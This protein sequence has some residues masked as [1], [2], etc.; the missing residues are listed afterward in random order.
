MSNQHTENHNAELTFYGALQKNGVYE[1]LVDKRNLMADS[2][3][4]TPI[5]WKQIHRANVPHLAR[6]S[7]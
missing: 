7:R 2:T 4:L 5:P 3:G 1:S 6:H